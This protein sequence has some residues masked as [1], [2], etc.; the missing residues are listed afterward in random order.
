MYSRFAYLCLDPTFTPDPYIRSLRWAYFLEEATGL[1]HLAKVSIDAIG[2]TNF[3]LTVVGDMEPATPEIVQ[4]YASI[5]YTGSI[6]RQA[7]FPS[8]IPVVEAPVFAYP[9]SSSSSPAY[10]ASSSSTLNHA[11]NSN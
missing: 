9:S 1:L 10:V 4:R 7:Y 11:Q 5:V 2:M 3:K 8:Q 6:Y